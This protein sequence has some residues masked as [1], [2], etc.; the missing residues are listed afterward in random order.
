MKE[1]SLILW[2][3]LFPVCVALERLLIILGNSKLT[4]DYHIQPLTQKNYHIPLILYVFGISIITI[5]IF[6]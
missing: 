3:C 2:I 4:K 6:I 1:L 5:L